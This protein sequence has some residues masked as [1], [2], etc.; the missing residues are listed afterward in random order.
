[1]CTGI[2][3]W[4]FSIR[5]WVT[6]LVLVSGVLGLFGSLGFYHLFMSIAGIPA[7]VHGGLGR[8]Q[9]K[10]NRTFVMTG[11]VTGIAERFFFTCLMACL[12][13]GDV[14][15][16]AIA[17]VAMKAQSHYNIFSDRGLSSSAN[18]DA[19]SPYLGRAYAAI[20]A[21]FASLMF[22]VWGGHIWN[23]HIQICR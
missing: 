20:L 14:A 18:T 4:I 21:T 8:S 1:M 3:G 6:G 16:A 23:E 12:S 15:S 11:I 9:L 13:Q 10:P 22:A 17:W 2:S 5:P 7:S 19:K